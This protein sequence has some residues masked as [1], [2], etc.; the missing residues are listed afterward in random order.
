MF[1]AVGVLA[2]QVAATRHAANLIG[3]GVPRRLLPDPDG[4]D[5]IRGSAAAVGQPLG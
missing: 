3:A 4:G 2:S 5:S 1:M